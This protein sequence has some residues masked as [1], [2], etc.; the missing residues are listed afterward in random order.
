MLRVQHPSLQETSI[1]MQKYALTRTKREIE[2]TSTQPSG[3]K[4]KLADLLAFAGHNDLSGSHS[5]QMI[6]EAPLIVFSHLRWHFVTQRPQH[7]LS[8]AAQS[9]RVYFWEEPIVHTDPGELTHPD[10]R[11]E[12]LSVEESSNVTVVRPHLFQ[13][14]DV[15]VLQRELLD[16]FL[17]EQGVTRFDRW[18]YTPMALRFSDHLQ[19]GVTV[20]DCMD[21]LSAF[22]GAPPELIRQEKKLFRIAD[23]IFTGGHSLYEAK[24]SH[25]RNVHPFPSSIDV[26]HFAR[27]RQIETEP[28]DQGAIRHPRAGYAGVIDERFD[29]ELVRELASLRPDVQFVFL[30]PV[31]K[32]DPA[33]LPQAANI[34]YLGMKSYR[35]LPWYLAGWDAALLP[36]AMNESTR[37]ISPTKTPEYLAAGKRVV[38][39]PIRDVVRDY[40]KAK[41]VEI[42]SDA[43]HFSEA[44]D[45]AFAARDDAEWTARVERKLA[46]SSWDR[47]WAAML[48][49]I[50]QIRLRKATANNLSQD[51]F[52]SS[53]DSITEEFAVMAK[54]SRKTTILGGGSAGTI[55]GTPAIEAA[56]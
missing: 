16:R 2:D 56:S 55:A 33:N 20:Y 28:A 29:I 6:A 37:Y 48:A 22:L 42:A 52:A 50:H 49:E 21:E 36:F 38:S 45:R 4:V 53:R 15:I 17:D 32:I 13:T 19:A 23:V 9:R 31:V 7:L 14:E 54:A 43:I 30:G 27:A 51:R 5:V 24:R 40:G 10:C 41:L 39:T 8:R 25:H 47:T 3:A 35:E 18:Y 11:L 34:H 12:F 44:L 46:A 26:P 1:T